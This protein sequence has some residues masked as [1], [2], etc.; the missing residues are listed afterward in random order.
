MIV[1]IAKPFVGSLEKKYAKDAIDSGWISSNG[2]YIQKFE[3]EI[4]K[5]LKAKKLIPRGRFF[6][7]L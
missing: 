1:P 6:M 2:K 5:K 7:K 3:A 4:K